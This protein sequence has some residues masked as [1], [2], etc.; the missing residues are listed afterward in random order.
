LRDDAE[1]PETTGP[2]GGDLGYLKYGIFLGDNRT[3]SVT[4][5]VRTDDNELRAMLLDPDTFDHAARTLPATATW[6]EADRA[7]AITPV[8]V[9]GGL[10]N[11]RVR[12]TDDE[13][14][15]IVLGLH[16]VGDAHTCTNPLYGRGCSLAMVQADLL[17]RATNAHPDDALERGR[18]YEAACASEVLP[19]YRASVQQDRANREQAQREKAI[20]AGTLDPGDASNDPAQVA[21]DVMR[22]GLMPAVRTDPQVFRA[23]I[24]TFNLLTTPDAMLTDAEV[25][26]RILEAYQDRDNRPPE[27]VLGPSRQEMLLELS[28]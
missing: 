14:T 12:Y 24:R 5:A 2:I 28:R 9:M 13:G 3:Y 8:E 25:F 19:W 18:M 11:R 16:A 20:A 7:T 21:Q 23:F 6:T 22:Q 15:P 10:V 1:L 17:A 26:G 4:L 27:P